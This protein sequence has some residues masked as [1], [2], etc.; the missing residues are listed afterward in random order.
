MDPTEVIA[1]MNSQIKL[2][3]PRRHRA[4]RVVALRLGIVLVALT[5][6]LV[7]ATSAMA[8]S[9]SSN[10]YNSG[11]PFLPQPSSGGMPFTGLD[12]GVVLA[13]GV[14]TLCI[15]IAVRRLSRRVG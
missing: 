7:F 8:Q 6:L 10:A 5:G 11:P 14:L 9:A 4:R 3:A 15:G 1:H 13:G 12:V 2:P